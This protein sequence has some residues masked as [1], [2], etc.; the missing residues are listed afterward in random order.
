MP[1][2]SLSVIE[3]LAV[4]SM[5]TVGRSANVIDEA[6]GLEMADC[7][8]EAFRLAAE[9]EKTKQQIRAIVFCSRKP[10]S[11]IVGAD[12]AF[13]LG[14]T[15]PD[16]AAEQAR[17]FR[18][19]LDAIENAPVPTVA[20]LNG[21]A[22]G[23]GL[24]IALACS[25]R[26]ADKNCKNIGLPEV[27]IGVL[28]GGGGTVRLPRLIGLAR[29]LP[30]LLGGEMITGSAALRMGLVD[31]LF[32]ETQWPA[33]GGA[34]P[35]WLPALLARF[36]SASGPRVKGPESKYSRVLGRTWA[37]QQILY[38]LSLRSVDKATHRKFPSPYVLL[39]TIF[40]CW[41]APYKEAF[42]IETRAYAKLAMTAEAKSIMGL[43]LSSRRSQKFCENYGTEEATSKDGDDD[44]APGGKN[45][46][47]PASVHLVIAGAGWMGTGIGQAYL[48]KGI[49]LTF[50]DSSETALHAARKRVAEM[51]AEKNMHKP[52]AARHRLIQEKLAN[53]HTRTEFT[54]ECFLPNKQTVV[55]ECITENLAAKQELLANIERVAQAAGQKVYFLSNTSSLRIADIG[56]RAKHPENV[57]G[58]H[59]FS[60]LYNIT[61][62]VELILG[63]GTSPELVRFTAKLAGIIGKTPVLVK[64][65]NG[66][67]VNRTFAIVYSLGNLLAVY[68]ACSMARVDDALRSFGFSDGP[69]GILDTVGI[70][71]A[72]KVCK[73]LSEMSP[74]ELSEPLSR[75]LDA[76]V[77]KGFTGMKHAKG[78]SKGFYIYNNARKVGPNPEMKSI[79]QV[80]RSQLAQSANHESGSGS[81]FTRRIKPMSQDEVRDVLVTALLNKCCAAV[82]E[83]IATPEDIDLLSVM[84]FGFP[85]QYGGVFSYLDI[86]GH[87]HTYGKAI[88]TLDAIPDIP[89]LE[90][91]ALLRDKGLAKEFKPFVRRKELCEKRPHGATNV[92][93]SVPFFV[94]PVTAG[95]VAAL[96]IAGYVLLSKL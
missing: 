58:M 92:A 35:S 16:V 82:E 73:I 3:G 17:R 72:V 55:L 27:K 31:A 52:K 20:I 29:S 34:S 1:S 78:I 2:V 50:L 93:T 44:A 4:V 12:I 8:K 77:D 69:F 94:D 90:P 22:L 66:F 47:D 57:M 53:L 79:F 18:E 19:L 83:G 64:D 42:E 86:T 70:P 88:E 5:D 9:G 45:K 74:S 75:V 65:V 63:P 28:P 24:E 54:S 13:Q 36:E 26:V 81:L 41:N 43:F 51:F 61:P 59:Y 68:G 33:D 7:L 32:D 71:T 91:C 11:F 46:L 96:G 89:T 48:A 87:K 56:E 38:S 6:F 85:P 23:G 15:D 67:F 60:P 49:T 40:A 30:L 95:V 76:M 14:L 62:S 37:E 21:M 25:Y 80:V 10:S 84:A 39:E